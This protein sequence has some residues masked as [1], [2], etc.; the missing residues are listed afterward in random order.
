MTIS[1]VKGHKK[2][3]WTCRRLQH[4][5]DKKV[6]Y[7]S[8]NVILSAAVS[9]S[10]NSWQKA[11]LLFKAMNLRAPSVRQFTRLQTLIVAPTVHQCWVS[12]QNMMATS[13]KDANCS[14]IVA[15]DG[16]YLL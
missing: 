16:E 3:W 1:C 11:E 12:E 5:S 14:V 2:V 9:L 7:C 4:R 8:T 6:I 13:L 15:G 10:G